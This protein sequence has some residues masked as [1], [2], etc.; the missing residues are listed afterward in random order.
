MRVARYDECVPYY[1]RRWTWEESGT[2]SKLWLLTVGCGSV[3]E[4]HSLEWGVS[5][6]VQVLRVPF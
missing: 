6:D 4:E 3:H 2:R 1:G 5:G